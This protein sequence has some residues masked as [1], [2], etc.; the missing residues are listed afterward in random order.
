MR[1]GLVTDSTAQLTASEVARFA[2]LTG[3]LF[4]SVPLT[5][6]VGGV[7][8]TDGEL[9]ID[10]VCSAM[11]DGT[12]VG[13][14][15][16]TPARF[17]AAYADLLDHGAEAILVVTMS[18]DLSGTRDS[19]RSAA[20]DQ[21]VR[22]E[23]VDSR[24][25]SAGLAGAVAMGAAGI[26]EGRDLPAIAGTVTDWC[27]GE[28][29]TVFAPRSLEHLR[30]GGRIGAASSLLGRALQIVPVLGLSG[31]TVTPVARVRTRAKAIE[32]MSLIA[33][34]TASRLGDRQRGAVVEVQHADGRPEDPD[35]LALQTRLEQQGLVTRFRTLSP[36]I[37]AHVGPGTLGI[38]VQTTPDPAA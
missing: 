5:V 25:T 22:I 20:A 30:R 29:M 7:A 11:T 31:G 26:A 10:V 34:E 35:V 14:S 3:G 28:T 1:I 21:P 9:D 12:E 18:G 17:T 32:R 13:T 24:T 37:T 19:A 8:H 33:G 2:E 16:A 6:L 27:A 4:R 36:I 15:M 23:V 38:T